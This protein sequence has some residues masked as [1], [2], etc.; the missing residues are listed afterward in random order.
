M[1][2]FEQSLQGKYL[3]SLV[4]RRTSTLSELETGSLRRNKRGRRDVKIKPV[5]RDLR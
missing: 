2:R 3:A 5:V 1:E 4:K